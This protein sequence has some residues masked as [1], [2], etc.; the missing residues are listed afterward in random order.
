MNQHECGYEPCGLCSAFFKL[1]AFTTHCA[2]EGQLTVVQHRLQLC[3][4]RRLFFAAPNS[5]NHSGLVESLSELFTQVSD[6]ALHRV[7]AYTVGCVRSG[8][9]NSSRCVMFAIT[10]VCV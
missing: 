6:A 4:D 9:A 3:T 2:S 10:A 5:P 7:A 8:E 1:R